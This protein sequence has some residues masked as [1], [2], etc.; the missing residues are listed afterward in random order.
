MRLR[1]IPPEAY[2][3]QVLPLTAPLWAGGRD[4]RDYARHTLEV[5]RSPY[6]RRYYRTIGLYD[7]KALV[8]SF[9]RY[10]RSLREGASR[11]R[12]LGFGAVFTPPE[13]RGRGYA[14]V[15]LATALDEA[16]KQGYEIA[17]LFS[18][19]R[20]QF[21]AALGFRTLPSRRF[22][23]RA[24]AL[25]ALRLPVA[26]L[27]TR[28]WERVV[29]LFEENERR[30]PAAFVRSRTVWQWI[31]LRMAQHS[32]QPSGDVTNLVLRRGRTI[33]A[34]VIG[35]RSPQRDEYFLE[36]LGFNDD[37]AADV[38]ALLRA[39]AGDLRRVAGWLPPLA[40]RRPLSRLT[41][42][43]R[44]RAILMMAP[45]GARGARML[46]GLFARANEEFAWSADHV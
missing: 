14:S 34:Y 42:R 6:G 44:E 9:K 16:R 23:L 15:M 40:A 13:Y 10:E 33:A 31:R 46:A 7:G 38:P 35:V 22:S 2:A 3:S 37:A 5:A 26:A 19:I 43:K 30:R 28:D 25:P 20:P 4:A 45:L 27:E 8:A 21:Y 17:F 41:V 29:P 1:E 18:D 11:L 39:A 32:E 12:A 36:E 24:D